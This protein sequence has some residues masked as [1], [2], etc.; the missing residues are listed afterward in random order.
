MKKLILFFTVICFYCVLQAQTADDYQADAEKGV[1]EAQ[2]KLG[3]D[4]GLEADDN[5]A[6]YWYEEALKNGLNNS[7]A[8]ASKIAVQMLKEAGYSSS[9]RKIDTTTKNGIK[10]VLETVLPVLPC[11]LTIV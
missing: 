5:T 3:I 6:L 7:E 1:V 4:L 10:P 2:Y 8:K 11:F 9:K